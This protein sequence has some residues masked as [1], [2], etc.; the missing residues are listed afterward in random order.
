M[1][2]EKQSAVGTEAVD[3]VEAVPTAPLHFVGITP[4]RVADTRGNGFT[5]QYGAPALT[6]AGRNMVITAQCGIPAD[7]Q[8]VSFN[9]TA[10]NVPAAGFLVAYPTGGAF[11]PVATMTYNQ[12]TPNLSN[13]AVVPLGAGGA[14][15]VVA[16]V[17]NIDLVVDVNGYYRPG[18]VTGLNGLSGNVTLAAGSNVTITPSGQTLTVASSSGPGGRVA[19]G[20][21]WSDA[22]ARRVQ[23]GR[24]QH[25]EEQR[26][27]RDPGGSS[28]AA[29]RCRA[30][31]E[32]EFNP[33]SCLLL[34][35]QHVS[36]K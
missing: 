13:A 33:F 2:N 31:E 30:S 16:A 22:A 34:E 8:A 5:G 12:N 25:L 18:V 21:T 3:A 4:C 1:A 9:F 19:H 20:Y 36:G 10:V 29:G 24:Q 28:D 35:Q 14:I 15:T 7:A 11:P 17:V 6:P 27:R 32:G 23:L 26:H